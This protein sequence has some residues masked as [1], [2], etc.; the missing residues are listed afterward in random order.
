MKN[1]N[2]ELHKLSKYEYA[3]SDD[4]SKNV[5]KAIHKDKFSQKIKR[6]V[7]YASATVAA[8]FVV[9][10]FT[11]TGLDKEIQPASFYDISR[12]GEITEKNSDSDRAF[13]SS[14]LASQEDVMEKEAEKETP[15]V[16]NALAESTTG[17]DELSAYDG[18]Y[19]TLRNYIINTLQESNIQVEEIEGGFR[20]K[21]TK[22]TIQEILY[23][24]NLEIEEQG[25]WTIIKYRT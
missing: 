6:I 1:L 8:C 7:P 2:D 3:V 17:Y 18:N 11:K 20:A 14:D 16:E 22:E 19:D 15:I 24:D 5:M 25:E 12:S 10:V 23:Y 9:M 4:F 21:A 13:F